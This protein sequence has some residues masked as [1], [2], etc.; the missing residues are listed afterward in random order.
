MRAGLLKEWITFYGLKESRTPSGAVEKKYDEA[1]LKV[2]CYRKKI[3][4]P[5]GNGLN[6]YEEF[7]ANT[8]IFQVRFNP[9][10]SERQRISYQGRMYKIVLLDKQHEDNTYLIT[11]S[12]INE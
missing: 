2:R 11:C 1:V 3:T 8:L 7:T 6:A 9:L 10:I 4:A 5:V 12:K